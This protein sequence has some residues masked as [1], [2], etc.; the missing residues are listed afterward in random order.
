[1]RLVALVIALLVGIAGLGYAATCETGP[2]SFP[3]L[4]YLVFWLPLTSILS[5][6]ILISSA[7]RLKVNWFTTTGVIG[8]I[9]LLQLVA[10]WIDESSRLT[11]AVM[12]LVLVVFAI[13]AMAYERGVSLESAVQFANRYGRW[14]LLAVVLAA[15]GGLVYL[16]GQKQ[17]AMRELAEWKAE[18]DHKNREL[19]GLERA[20]WLMSRVFYLNDYSEEQFLRDKS[21]RLRFWG[22]FRWDEERR[23]LIITQRLFDDE[24]RQRLLPQADAVL[25]HPLLDTG[26]RDDLDGGVLTCEPELD[27]RVEWVIDVDQLS[28][29]SELAKKLTHGVASV[30]RRLVQ[31]L[32]K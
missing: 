12:P 3:W 11:L 17:I 1:M 20:A 25:E 29:D 31:E 18:N 23:R 32:A 7:L 15:I 5:F 14:G 28:D 30:G 22:E 8:G 2:W 10:M 6:A 19:S 26:V 4:L 16:A 27:C 21:C 13:G 24:T 9:A